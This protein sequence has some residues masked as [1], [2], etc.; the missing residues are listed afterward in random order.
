MRMIE[1]KTGNQIDNLI[2]ASDAFDVRRCISQAVFADGDDSH[3]KT[4]EDVLQEIES[5]SVEETLGFLRSV[6]LLVERTDEV[7]S[8]QIGNTE[9]GELRSFRIEEIE[10]PVIE[11]PSPVLVVQEDEGGSEDPGNRKNAEKSKEGS[12]LIRIEPFWLIEEEE[13]DSKIAR[14]RSEVVRYDIVG[15]NDI[16]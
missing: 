14:D 5:V 11:I 12:L 16:D 8:D 2:V 3:K 9:E 10:L 13:H 15:G 4:N 7:E 1:K 6:F